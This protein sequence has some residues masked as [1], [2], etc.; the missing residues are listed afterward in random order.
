MI[1]THYLNIH[2]AHSIYELP[3]RNNRTCNF[4]EP[5]MSTPAKFMF[6][7]LLDAPAAP[8]PI[9]F[10]EVEQLKL[11][12]AQELERVKAQSFE[13]GLKA[14]RIESDQTL[15]HELHKMLDQLIQN[16]ATLTE[17]N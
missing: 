10:D 6:D 2:L 16:K 1:T 7:T 4:G 17:R 8:P 14:G 3:T 5:N 15:E 12:H 11:D 9:A 13:E